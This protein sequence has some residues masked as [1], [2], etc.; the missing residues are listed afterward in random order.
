MD[1]KQNKEIR[2]RCYWC[3]YVMDENRIILKS[4][5]ERDKYEGVDLPQCYCKE[6]WDYIE[7]ERKEY[8]F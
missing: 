5:E 1:K 3:N 4:K 8:D 7:W 2:Y 6:C